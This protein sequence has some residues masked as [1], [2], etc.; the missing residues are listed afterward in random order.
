MTR[1]ETCIARILKHE[2]GFVDHPDDPG[3]A[4]N[5]GITLET[6]R[7][8]VKPEGT[9]HDLRRLTEAQAIIVYKRQYWDK[10]CADLLPVGVDYTVADYA[11]NSGPSRAAKHLQMVVGAPVDGIIGPKTIA[12][13]KSRKSA[14]VINGLCDSRLRFLKRLHHWSVFG[15]GWKHRVEDVRADALADMAAL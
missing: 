12:A 8:Y 1:A 11:V 6:F 15:R 10:V 9:I 13:V 3:G 7:R 2:G 4:T 5:K 14:D